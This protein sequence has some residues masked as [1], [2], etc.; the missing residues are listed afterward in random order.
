MLQDA[1]R[2]AEQVMPDMAR[3]TKELLHL[4]G[5]H[6][7][8]VAGTGIDPINIALWGKVLAADAAQHGTALGLVC[9][10]SN[11]RLVL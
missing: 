3:E 8:Y 7:E 5:Q 1:W 6:A 9:E 10:C 11:G 4:T 2:L